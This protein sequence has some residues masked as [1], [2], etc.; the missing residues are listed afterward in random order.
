MSVGDSQGIGGAI[1]AGVQGDLGR[2]GEITVDQISIQINDRHHLG[3]HGGQV[4]S[5]RGDGNEVS[6]ACRNVPGSADHEALLC[7]V[8]TSGCYCFSFVS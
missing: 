5:G 1:Y 8:A 6:L 4:G 2:G 3:C 7:Q